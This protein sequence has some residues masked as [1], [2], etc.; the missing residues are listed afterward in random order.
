MKCLKH[1]HAQQQVI[2]TFFRPNCPN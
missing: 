2:P 1:I